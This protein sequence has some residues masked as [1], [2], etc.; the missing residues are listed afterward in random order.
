MAA[1]RK[2]RDAINETPDRWES[3]AASMETCIR[4]PRAEITR[5]LEAQK[6]GVVGAVERLK[7]VVERA[8]G[9]SADARKKVAAEIEQL[10]RQIHQ[11][12]ADDRDSALDRKQRVEKVRQNLEKHLDRISDDVHPDFEDAVRGWVRA[13]MEFDTGHELAAQRFAYEQA[14][15][16]AQFEAR[17]Q[18]ML[19]NIEQF[20]TMLNEKRSSAAKQ[21]RPFGSEMNAAYDRIRHS[22]LHLAD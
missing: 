18:E 9:L 11:G 3:A 16:R 14:E 5:R 20:R 12:K 4:S 22:F 10:K 8:N 21:G 13:Q 2:V 17:K 15:H 19:R 1:L 7:Q 6:Q